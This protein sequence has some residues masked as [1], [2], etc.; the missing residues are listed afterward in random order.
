MG[1]KCSCFD[2]VKRSHGVTNG[3]SAPSEPQAVTVAQ[4]P[5]TAKI[6][7]DP[8]EER[9]REAVGDE[10]VADAIHDDEFARVELPDEKAESQDA[11]RHDDSTRVV[12][13]SDEKVEAEDTDVAKD[14]PEVE[15]QQESEPMDEGDTHPCTN[16]PGETVPECSTSCADEIWAEASRLSSDN[17]PEI[18]CE[19]PLAKIEDFMPGSAPDIGENLKREDSG[20]ALEIQRHLPLD[21]P[22]KVQSQLQENENAS[23]EK[24][25]IGTVMTEQEVSQPVPGETQASTPA[26]R[27]VTLEEERQTSPRDITRAR[28]END[29]DDDQDEPRD[30]VIYQDTSNM[31]ANA[32]SEVHSKPEHVTQSSGKAPLP[33]VEREDTKGFLPVTIQAHPVDSNIALN[34]FCGFNSCCRALEEEPDIAVKELARMQ[35]TMVSHGERLDVVWR[36]VAKTYIRKDLACDSARLY[37]L[38]VEDYITVTAIVNAELRVIGPA[39]GWVSLVSPGGEPLVMIGQTEATEVEEYPAVD[40]GAAFL[41]SF[42]QDDVSSAN[43]IA[44]DMCKSG[45]PE[46]R[47]VAK[48]RRALAEGKIGWRNISLMFDQSI[49]KSRA[50]LC[51]IA[52]SFQAAILCGD[53]AAAEE[54]L[55]RPGCDSKL[56]DVMPP[57][58]TTMLEELV[59][60]TSQRN[61]NPDVVRIWEEAL[62]T[63]SR[64]KDSSAVTLRI[65]AL[66]DF[67]KVVY[68]V[69]TASSSNCNGIYRFVG[70][71]ENRPAYQLKQLV[72]TEESCMIRWFP[73]SRDQFQQGGEEGEWRIVVEESE[74]PLFRASGSWLPPTSGWLPALR[75]G[76]P[77]SVSFGLPESAAQPTP[78]DA[79]TSR[80]VSQPDFH[81]EDH[82]DAD[83]RATEELN[84]VA[85]LAGPLPEITSETPPP[86]W[87][88]SLIE[89]PPCKSEGDAKAEND[90]PQLRRLSFGMPSCSEDSDSQRRYQKFPHLSAQHCWQ[91]IS[92]HR[93]LATAS[94]AKAPGI[95][96]LSGLGDD[97]PEDHHILNFD[98]SGTASVSPV[99]LAEVLSKLGHPAQE[100]ELWKM[101]AANGE[102]SAV[103]LADVLTLLACKLDGG[104]D[105]LDEKKL[106]V[107]FE[108][109]DCQHRGDLTFDDLKKGTLNLKPLL[110]HYGLADLSIEFTKTEVTDMICLADS[111]RDGI[112]SYG[113]FVMA[114]KMSCPCQE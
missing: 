111:N 77:P 82:A 76:S 101:A 91:L 113:E 96:L 54:I 19:S 37:P 99:E 44:A 84:M 16:G 51:N 71:Q 86:M 92:L 9:L 69:E 42:S 66:R 95:D 26:P 102:D 59:A 5:A 34:C 22:E 20:N 72:E 14:S 98:S 110:S 18:D 79:A 109:L 47:H 112:V 29:D 67:D 1:S 75:S 35:P 90:L 74:D 48:V 50:Q 46:P 57:R 36:V 8:S 17:E 81:D 33:G 4:L 63:I 38:E 56:R 61:A 114:L 97:A 12:G 6:R 60:I 103:D 65:A 89:Q 58:F 21:E 80:K 41:T 94:A 87:L 43:V 7:V 53:A 52:T 27:E 30:S 25:P 85:Q 78:H 70:E 104:E 64:D 31:Y 105:P 55:R 106:K 108:A 100:V 11:I 83:R 24:F 3:G 62:Q 2:G 39:V 15:I 28:S 10:N 88:A 49:S 73:W 23:Y 32:W 93:L 40:L 13:W 68:T 45:G 107:A